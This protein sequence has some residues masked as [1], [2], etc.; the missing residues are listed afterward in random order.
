ME[1]EHDLCA[2][3]H[4]IIL[5]VSRTKELP[6]A[7]ANWYY[8][9]FSFKVHGLSLFGAHYVDVNSHNR[10]NSSHK[11]QGEATPNNHLRSFGE[12]EV[13]AFAIGDWHLHDRGKFV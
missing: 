12:S 11:R 5:Q 2:A 13:V 3:E 8:S 6:R 4:D 7:S 10:C 9:R 1:E